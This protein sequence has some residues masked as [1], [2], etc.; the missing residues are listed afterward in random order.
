MPPGQ[1]TLLFVS[2]QSFSKGWSILSPAALTNASCPILN[3]LYLRW[4]ALHPLEHPAERPSA[5]SH[6]D[7]APTWLAWPKILRQKM[8]MTTWGS[9]GSFP[10]RACQH[11]LESTLL[12]MLSCTHSNCEI[13]I[14]YALLPDPL[15]SELQYLGWAKNRKKKKIKEGSCSFCFLDNSF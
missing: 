15:I 2:P 6:S 3:S 10:L 14:N 13:T 1:S 8:G 7:P 4:A 12:T 9:A 5:L 11:L